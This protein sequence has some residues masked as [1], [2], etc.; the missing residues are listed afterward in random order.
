MEFAVKDENISRYRNLTGLT[1]EEWVNLNIHIFIAANFNR[2][3]GALMKK[4]GYQ[5]L[6]SDA[7][8]TLLGLYCDVGYKPLASVHQKNLDAVGERRNQIMLGTLKMISATRMIDAIIG[9][10]PAYLSLDNITSPAVNVDK[11][12]EYEEHTHFEYADQHV[13]E[14]AYFAAESIGLLNDEIEEEQAIDDQRLSLM[15]EML[16]SCLT[17]TQY[18]HLRYAVC[19]NLDCNEIAEQ[20]G[21]TLTNVRVML[22]NARRRMFELMPPDMAKKFEEC[23]Y[24]K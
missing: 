22:L 2:Y 20:T 11:S 3:C 21:S 6:P 9:E 8:N 4:I 23:I 14:P 17:P 18:Q 12:E 15:I 1:Q 10:F 5:H 16:R 13:E 19:D 7:S 24:R